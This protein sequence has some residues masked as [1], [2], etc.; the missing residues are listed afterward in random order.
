MP[1]PAVPV[2]C[3]R[4]GYDLRGMR[5]A[6]AAA[7][8]P[9][10]HAMCSEC[11][12]RFAWIDVLDPAR[13]NV[14]WLYEHTPRRRGRWPIIGWR[15]AWATL[16][17]TLAPWVFWRDVQLHAR[18]SIP[19]LL[20]WLGVL[21]VPLHVVWSLLNTWRR[22]VYFKSAA[23]GWGIVTGSQW[24]TFFIN[25]W[26]YPLA[27]LRGTRTAMWSVHLRDPSYSFLLPLGASVLMPVV[28]LLLSRT[29]ATSRVRAGHVLRAGV[30]GLAWVAAWYLLWVLRTS[31]AVFEEWL[32]GGVSL[33]VLRA[34]TAA[35]LPV[36]A[37]Q[38]GMLALGIWC[39]WFGAYWWWALSRGLRLPRPGLVWTLLMVAALLAGAL[40]TWFDDRLWHAIGDWLS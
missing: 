34:R 21:V 27:E 15:R 20:V 8:Q 10:E 24:E 30:Y 26:L 28:L 1:D 17:R 4:C 5:A 14:P 19:R 13:H 16:V 12:L 32:S 33:R 36:S 29:R 2:E 25:A 18:I 35:T 39:A 37:R 31:V 11:G 6:R 7:E 3:P 40:A 9:D 23:P 38:L 22:Y